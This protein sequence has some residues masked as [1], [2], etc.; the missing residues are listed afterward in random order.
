M[1]RLDRR[2]VGILHEMQAHHNH[3]G[4]PEEDDVEAGDQN[5]GLIVFFEFRRLVRPAERRERP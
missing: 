5:I 2:A 1:E 3:A 4:N